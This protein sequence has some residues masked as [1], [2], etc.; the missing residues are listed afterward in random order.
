MGWKTI[1]GHRYYYT[2]KRVGKRIE[3]PYV[4]SGESAILMAELEAALRLEDAV[5]RWRDREE[6]EDADEEERTTAEW[7][8]DV[9]TQADAAMV[10]AGFHK[11]KGQ[12]RRKRK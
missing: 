8:D 2:S 11:H 4:G 9:Q 7:F 6:R 5:E 10:E 12:W 3:T 1:N